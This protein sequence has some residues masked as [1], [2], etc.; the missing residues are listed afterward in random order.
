M[1]TRTQEAK[2]KRLKDTVAEL[3]AKLTKA[4]AQNDKLDGLNAAL[5]LEN[6]EQQAEIERLKRGEFICK[7]CGLRKNAEFEPGDF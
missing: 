5:D 2:M 3:E 1:L 4:E 6:K 7:K